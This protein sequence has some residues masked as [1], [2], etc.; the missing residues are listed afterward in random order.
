MFFDKLKI[1]N[2]VHME[3]RF[4]PFS[5]VLEE[6]A[7]KLVAFIAELKFVIQ[8]LCAFFLNKSTFLVSWAATFAIR[9][10]YSFSFS[11]A[12]A[13]TV[14]SAPLSNYQVLII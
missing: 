3:M 5:K 4:I 7:G 2:H 11:I 10:F 1:I 12:R 8:N 9:Q 14:Q 13:H 6:F